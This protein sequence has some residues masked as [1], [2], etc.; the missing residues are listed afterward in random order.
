LNRGRDEQGRIMATLEDYAVVRELVSD[1]VSQGVGASVPT[2]VR[3]TVA[4]ASTSGA[5]SCPDI[6]C[7][8]ETGPNLTQVA[9][10]LGIDKSAA[11][12]RVT[13]AIELGYLV[14]LEQRK[15]R[16]M[17]LALGE[18]LPDQDSEILPPADD[19]RLTGCTVDGVSGEGQAATEPDS[20][21]ASLTR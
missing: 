21:E 16:P 14:N 3:E 9:Q 8:Y 18:P 20:L 19:P 10:E 2:T 5:R 6:A 15:G 11:S 7:W 13:Q 17:R 12:R 1:L 4:A